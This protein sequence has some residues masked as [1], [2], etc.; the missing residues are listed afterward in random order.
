M[1]V[2]GKRSLSAESEGSSSPA[3][4][5]AGSQAVAVEKS[6]RRCPSRLHAANVRKS[7]EMFV[8]STPNTC[9]HAAGVCEPISPSQW[10]PPWL[11]PRSVPENHFGWNAAPVE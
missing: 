8:S 5:Q 4:G 2:K 3:S 7:L 6:Y 1:G 10:L 11:L 9:F